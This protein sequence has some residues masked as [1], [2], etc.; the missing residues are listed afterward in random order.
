MFFAL[1]GFVEISKSPAATINQKEWLLGFPKRV[2]NG[3]GRDAK[4]MNGYLKAM[5]ISSASMTHMLRHTPAS[6][7]MGATR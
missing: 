6:E 7:N 1:A 5:N 4:I 2:Q 3:L